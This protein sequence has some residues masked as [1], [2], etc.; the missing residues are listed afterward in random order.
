MKVP[1]NTK[2][3][4][5]HSIQIT[6]IRT[7]R[8][9]KKQLGDIYIPPYQEKKSQLLQQ[10]PLYPT[11]ISCL[12]RW[13]KRQ[14][15]T[16]HTTDPPPFCFLVAPPTFVTS[17]LFLISLVIYQSIVTIQNGG[18]D[19]H[20]HTHRW[21]WQRSHQIHQLLFSQLFLLLHF[22]CWP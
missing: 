3:I 18:W 8:Y 16:T 22:F 15:K 6:K 13:R 20:I 19:T 7:P 9:S 21:R 5:V 4:G 17:L 10:L 2:Q 1:V 11:L 14:E 12:S